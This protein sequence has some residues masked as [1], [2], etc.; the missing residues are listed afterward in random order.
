MKREIT[1]KNTVLGV[2]LG[3]TRIKAVLC[4]EAGKVLAS[5]SYEWENKY[6]KNTKEV[7]NEKTLLTRF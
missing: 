4:D 3:S 2:E 5:G 7:Y 1:L 6:I